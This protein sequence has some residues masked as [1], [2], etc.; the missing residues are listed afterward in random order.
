MGAQQ[1]AEWYDEMCRKTANSRSE[2]PWCSPWHPIWEHVVKLVAVSGPSRIVELGCGPGAM[3]E[4]LHKKLPKVR[5]LGSDFSVVNIQIA[6]RRGLPK[7]YHFSVRDLVLEPVTINQPK[8]T[9]V[10][11]V[12]FLE[13]II[14]DLQVLD[15]LPIDTEVIF[16]LPD[17]DSE[18]HVRWFATA[19]EV[20]TRYRPLFSDLKV[21]TLE[22]GLR[23]Y[24]IGH[25]HRSAP[26]T[27]VPPTT[28]P[29]TTVP[30]TTLPQES[31]A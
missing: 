22:I 3:A 27:T 17:H 29:P 16:S 9:V 6:Q 8:C 15:R 18:G 20:D 11:T 24:F 1:N 28:G 4:M 5:Y 2:P 10:V 21:D 7:H 30:P 12:E 14:Q 19:E 25:G 13:H 31:A 23:K 26:V